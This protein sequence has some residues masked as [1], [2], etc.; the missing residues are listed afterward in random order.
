MIQK[1]VAGNTIHLKWTVMK[2]S[3]MIIQDAHVILQDVFKKQVP[4]EYTIQDNGTELVISG[5]YEGKDQRTF[6]KYNIILF[7]NYQN[8]NQNC[9]VYKDCFILVHALKNQL[10]TYSDPDA[11]NAFLLEINSDLSLSFWDQTI[12]DREDIIQSLSQ[13]SLVNDNQDIRLND[14][15]TH[16]DSS[17]KELSERIDNLSI[18][19]LDEL[20]QN[21]EDNEEVI[22]HYLAIADNSINEQKELIE[23]NSNT[24]DDVSTRLNNFKDNDFDTLRTNIYN[25]STYVRNVSTKLNNVSTRLNVLAAEVSEVISYD[26]TEL[27]GAI[28]NLSTNLES[29]SDKVNDVST[30][31]INVSTRLNNVSTKLNDL[32]TYIDN[33]DTG[34]DYDDTELKNRIA[35]VSQYSIDVSSKLNIL[36]LDFEYERQA[37]KEDDET[38]EDWIQD[39]SSYSINVS[40]RLNDL[41]TFAHNITPGTTPYD[42]T[43]VKSRIAD[44]SQYAIDLST[45]IDE[46]STRLSQS[47]GGSGDSISE[48]ERYARQNYTSAWYINHDL[49]DTSYLEFKDFVVYA[50]LI[51]NKTWPYSESVLNDSSIILRTVATGS[52]E[53]DRLYLIGHTPD[54]KVSMIVG[55]RETYLSQIGI[56]LSNIVDSSIWTS[57][58]SGEST[59]NTSNYLFYSFPQK[60]RICSLPD[61]LGQETISFRLED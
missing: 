13:I 41:S 28:D 12:T 47:G 51:S 58:Y 39:I 10:F 50:P 6:G 37:R 45:K 23:N 21:I 33:L 18:D 31:S 4:F 29:L 19:S 61:S 24:I 35:D 20:I 8:P 40:S 26:D 52:T 46:V 56:P 34:S 49:F 44:V 57:N 43:N 7:N 16:L 38:M 42:D 2:N 32:S 36:T 3:N 5:K 22:V 11:D 55:G 59:Y 54:Y 14:L 15:S 25:V 9:L 1:I 60:V 53:T 27:V 17:I 48:S 30:Y